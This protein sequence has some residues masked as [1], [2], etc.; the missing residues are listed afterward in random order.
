MVLH[1]LAR[2]LYGKKLPVSIKYKNLHSFKEG[3]ILLLRVSLKR[4]KYHIYMSQ[5]SS[6]SL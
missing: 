1:E 3:M 4:D 5:L 2:R 6:Q